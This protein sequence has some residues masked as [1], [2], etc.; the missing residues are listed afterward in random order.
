MKEIMTRTRNQFHYAKRRVKKMS[1]SLRAKRLLEESEQGSCE[2]LK[3]MKK[4]RGDKKAYG[5]LPNSVGGVSGEE[6]IVE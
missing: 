5:D 2:L 3:E 1:S 6:N 4:I